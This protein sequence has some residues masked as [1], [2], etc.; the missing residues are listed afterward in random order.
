MKGEASHRNLLPNCINFPKRPWK[1]SNRNQSLQWCH[2][3]WCRSI[4]THPLRRAPSRPRRRAA[5]VAFVLFRFFPIFELYFPP[6][7]FFLPRF[8]FPPFVLHFIA[9]GPEVIS[10]YLNQSAL[11][12]PDFW[13]PFATP[14]PHRSLPTLLL[15]LPLNQRLPQLRRT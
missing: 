2:P 6:D 15:S 1:R 8:L 13:A 14:L 4:H 3:R 10:R 9:R 5:V 12:S 11:I 7:F